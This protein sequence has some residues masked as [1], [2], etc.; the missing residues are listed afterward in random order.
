MLAYGILINALFSLKS[1]VVFP[2][3]P[4]EFDLSFD[5][6]SDLGQYINNIL[7]PHKRF[8]VIGPYLWRAELN[9]VNQTLANCI[10]YA[11][12]QSDVNILSCDIS[13][14]IDRQISHIFVHFGVH[15]LVANFLKEKI[16]PPPPTPPPLSK[17]TKIRVHVNMMHAFLLID[18]VSFV[19]FFNTSGLILLHIDSL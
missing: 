3:F 9:D 5:F 15:R 12:T 11:I 6:N 17:V 2:L 13:K 7:C 14:P 1:F 8:Y 18:L 19:F 4:N 10:N 16:K